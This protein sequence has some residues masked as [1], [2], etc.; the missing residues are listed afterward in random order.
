MERTFALLLCFICAFSVSCSKVKDTDAE[1]SDKSETSEVSSVEESDFS[2]DGEI[3]DES[4][5]EEENWYDDYS[6]ERVEHYGEPEEGFNKEKAIMLSS[7]FLNPEGFYTESYNKNTD[8]FTVEKYDYSFNKICSFDYV[9]D[10]HQEYRGSNIIRTVSDGG[11]IYIN[12]CEFC[13][14][15]DDKWVK[16]PSSLVKFDASGN[17]QWEYTFENSSAYLNDFYEKEG[18]YYLFGTL[19]NP[20]TENQSISYNKDICVYK[21][22]ADGSLIKNAEYGGSSYDSCSYAITENEGFRIYCYTQSKDGD[23]PLSGSYI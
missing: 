22:T 17:F 9:S 23:F 15:E 11:I 16:M 5:S 4:S 14:T 20:V 8:T 12:N 21:F 2:S 3:S 7:G 10:T 6:S 18:Y 13:K 19:E 1:M